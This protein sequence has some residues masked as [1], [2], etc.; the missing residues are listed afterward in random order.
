MRKFTS[1]LAVPLLILLFTACNGKL[2]DGTYILLDAPAETE[3]YVDQLN[4]QAKKPLDTLQA[5]TEAME[6][7]LNVDTAG[8]YMVSVQN[9]VS[10]PLFIKP[11]EK[12]KLS[13]TEGESW[14]YNVEGSEESERIK[15]II[16]I[17][18]GS[19]QIIDS[20]TTAMQNSEDPRAM[21]DRYQQAFESVVDSTR[22]VLLNMI[23]ENPGMMGNLFIWPQRIGRFT[24]VPA[25]EYYAYYDTV[26][27]ALMEKY[28]NNEHA[29]FFQMQVEKI[30]E[31]MDRQNQLDKKLDDIKVGSMAPDLAL[32]DAEGEIQKLSDLKGKYVLVDFWASWCRP[33]RVENPLL[34]KTYNEYKDKGFT[35]YSV[36]LDGDTRQPKAR[37]D[38]LKAIEKDGLSWDHHVSDLKGWSSKAV[39]IYGFQSIPFTV[40]VDP[41]GKI[42][43]VNLRGPT[44]RDKLAEVLG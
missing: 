14:N 31:Q 25:N 17:V 39:D 2:G 40:L 43:G 37:E 12:V 23:D 38:W 34:V 21:Q 6:V 35:I 9:K 11:G 24:L 10:A 28:P 27:A 13:L 22:M 1:Y 30:A 32:P 26:A 42:I 4:P 3:A 16:D 20:M 18:N 33:C 36:S 7:A 44:L 8:F 29:E 15:N 19:N 5:G 41:E